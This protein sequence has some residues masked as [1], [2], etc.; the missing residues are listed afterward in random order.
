MAAKHAIIDHPS[1]PLRVIITD[2]PPNQELLVDTYIPVF[3]ELNVSYLIRLCEP[4]YDTAVLQQAG[5]Q[6]I[7]SLSF[8]D[9][10]APVDSIVSEYRLLIDSI[11]SNSKPVNPSTT[12]PSKPTIAVHC[13]SGIGRAPLFALIPLVDSGM[14]R[15]EAVEYIRQRRRGAFNKVQLTW[16]LDEKDGLKSKRNSARKP[17][18]FGIKS[19]TAALNETDQRRASVASSTSIAASTSKKTGFLGGLFGKK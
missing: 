17:F 13:V 9:G 10:S 7:D 8:T 15:A 11:L 16:I 19:S 3:E 1:T 5:V 12:S 18:S 4:T 14:D 6:V 2:C